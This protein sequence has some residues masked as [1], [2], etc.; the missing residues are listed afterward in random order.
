M[1]RAL[2]DVPA[3]ARRGEVVEIRAMIAHP[4][5]TGFRTGYDGRRIARNIVERFVC[6][7]NDVAVFSARFYPSITANPFVSFT[8]VATESGVIACSWTDDRG[9]TRVETAKISVE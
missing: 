8:T 2:L 6:T 7:Y 5:E 1:K 4:M 3:K 9:E